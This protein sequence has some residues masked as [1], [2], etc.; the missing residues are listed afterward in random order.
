MHK[1]YIIGVTGGSGSGKTTLIRN[2]HHIFNKDEVCFLSMDNYYKRRDEQEMDINQ[3]KNFDLPSSFRREDFYSDLKKLIQG[4][5]VVIQEYTF[6][7]PL[8]IASTIT[9]LPAPVIIVEGIFVFYFAEIADLIDMKIF[10]DASEHL[11]VIRRI[12]RDAEE[13]NYPLEDVL[14]RYEHHVQPTYEKY[15]LPMKGAADILINNNHS[16]SVAL[17]VLIPFI[18]N[19]VGNQKVVKQEH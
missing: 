15:I 2:L 4:E 8:A 12:K 18:R 17:E 10:L 7:N 14:Y 6:N 1:P 13:R 11:K 9:Y 5:T 16:F 19:R 3:Q